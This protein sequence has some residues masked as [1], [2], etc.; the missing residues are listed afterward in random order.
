MHDFGGSQ[1]KY[2]AEGLAGL[3]DDVPNDLLRKLIGNGLTNKAADIW[4]RLRELSESDREGEGT[5]RIDRQTRLSLFAFC[6]T[7]VD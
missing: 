1:G 5:H 4:K 6:L 7:N 3:A 2:S